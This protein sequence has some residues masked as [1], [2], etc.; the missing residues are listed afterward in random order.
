MRLN[1]EFRRYL[2][3]ELSTARVIGMLVV[4]GGLFFLFGAATYESSEKGGG[5]G[6]YETLAGAALTVVTLIVLFWGTR[7]AASALVQEVADKTWDAQRLSSLGPWSMSWGKLMGSTVYVW[8]GIVL[9]LAV[10]A[11]SMAAW[12]DLNGGVTRR[13]GEAGGTVILQVLLGAVAFAVLVQATALIAALT[14]LHQR[15]T[16]RRFD[17]SFAQLAAL[18]VAFLAGSMVDGLHDQRTVWF[19]LVFFG[20]WF[21][22]I[23][24]CVFAGWSVI[25]VWRRMQ[26]ELQ[27]RMRPFVWPVFVLFMAAWAAGLTWPEQMVG[28]Y[29]FVIPA[30]LL[31][32]I[33][34]FAGYVPALFERLDPVRL[35]RLIGNMRSGRIG[36]V[37]SDAPL[38]FVNHLVA[39]VVV[40][41]TAVYLFHGTCLFQMD[42]RLPAGLWVKRR[43][44]ERMRSL[45]R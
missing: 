10:L 19:G 44:S 39:L 45:V 32:M 15:E 18:V 26:M 14:A 2:W 6:M 31:A 4:L 43:S 8:Y 13:F 33:V 42:I 16:T 37:L 35:R 12:N 36:E 28:A 30:V 41:A 29:R 9:C 5:V 38:W 7:L 1:P 22:I 21:A 3:L 11:V 27:V 24:L 40:G 25:G 20:P 23:S 34:V 17:V